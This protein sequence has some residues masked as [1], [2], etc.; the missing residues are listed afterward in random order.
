MG[1]MPQGFPNDVNDNDVANND[2]D[3]ND[4]DDND[5]DDNDSVGMHL[6]KNE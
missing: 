6:M 4:I 3:N 2:I 5:V 1:S